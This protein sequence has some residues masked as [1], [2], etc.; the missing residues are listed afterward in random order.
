MP[1]EVE[2]RK[3]LLE[4]SARAGRDAIEF[5]KN[6]EAR[7]SQEDEILCCANCLQCLELRDSGEAPIRVGSHHSIQV[8]VAILALSLIHI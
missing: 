6:M 4:V 1:K 5:W 8:R 3:D 7:H 2:K